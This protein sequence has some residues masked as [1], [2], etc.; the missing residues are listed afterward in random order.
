MPK[1]FEAIPHLR[2]FA[3]VV[4]LLEPLPRN[5]RARVILLL[6]LAFLPEMFTEPELM[7]LIYASRA[8]S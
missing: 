4:E 2:A 3:S 7:R 8:S 1:S 6:V 5:D